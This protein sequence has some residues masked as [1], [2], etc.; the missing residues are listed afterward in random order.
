[1]LE[2]K[3]DR[4]VFSFPEV[5]A[6][7][8]C[9]IEMQRTLRIPDDD[10]TYP[11]PPGLGR[12]PMRH[13][14]DYAHR[15]SPTWQKHGGV[16]LPMCQSEAMWLRF[17]CPTGY[18]FVLKVGA[19]KVNAVTGETW[20]DGLHRDPQDYVILPRQPWLDGFCVRKGVIRQFVAMPLGSGYSAEEQLTGRAEHGG[21]QIVAY[22]MKASVY[23]ERFE[24]PVTRTMAG[25][26]RSAQSLSLDDDF[27]EAE[28]AKADMGLAPGG[29][30]KQDIYDDTFGLSDWEQRH[31]SR[32]FVHLTNSMVWRELTGEAAPGVPPTAKE[33][34]QHGL[35]WFD[36]YAEGPAVPGSG[37][38]AGLDSV[39]TMA[40]KKGEPLP[41]NSSV[42]PGPV[43][44]VREGEF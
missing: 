44:T 26:I 39:A 32:V 8:R 16:M 6:Q 41:G 5:H 15:V 19:G 12:F 1:M 14:D 33:Y 10:R 22:P 25:A 43:K 7:A 20:V 21:L 3:G 36:H 11:L 30:M 34:A 29:S 17:T 18:P 9:E 28:S 37:A 23:R 42:H 13:V 38:L 27:L 31:K 35:P 24:R 40:N 4:L 2:L